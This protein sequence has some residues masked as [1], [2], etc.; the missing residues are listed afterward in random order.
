LGLSKDR[1]SVDISIERPLLVTVRLPSAPKSRLG[2]RSCR[3][4]PK[5]DS[6]RAATFGP[7][8][9]RSGLVP[10]L[11]FL[12]APTVFSARYLAGLLHP[13]ADRGVRLVSFEEPDLPDHPPPPKRRTGDRPA[14]LSISPRRS[15]PSK[16][17]PRRQPC[18]VTATSSLSSSG[19][20]RAH[21]DHPRTGGPSTGRRPPPTSGLC[22]IGESVAL[23]PCLHGRRLDA[24][25]GL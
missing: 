16:L 23:R 8:L 18:R 3:F 1:P 9:P 12:P 7:E 5:D 22:S 14:W 25:L 24:P 21:P 15:R 2:E 19:G 10:P 6:S 17:S 20:C 13:A 11:P 4:V